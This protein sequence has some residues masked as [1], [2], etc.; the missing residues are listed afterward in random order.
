MPTLDVPYYAQSNKTECGLAVLKML[1]GFRYPSA[2]EDQLTGVARGAIRQPE[3]DVEE[4]QGIAPKAM[5]DVMAFVEMH[6]F[7]YTYPHAN[8]SFDDIQRFIE[9]G[10]PI[11]AY[12]QLGL[13]GPYGHYA[14]IIGCGRDEKAGNRGYIEIHDPAGMQSKRVWHDLYPEQFYTPPGW[15]W[16]ESWVVSWMQP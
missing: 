8:L 2:T 11:L 1:L 4:E 6:A 15:I 5:G 9:G 3:A 12:V 10:S 14:L 7:Q 13:T 16:G